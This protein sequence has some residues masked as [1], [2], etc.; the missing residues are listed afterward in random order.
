[1]SL[2]GVLLPG[3][4]VS[5]LLEALSRNVYFGSD[6]SGYCV[7]CILFDRLVKALFIQFTGS[8]LKRVGNGLQE[9]Q[10]LI[11]LFEN[12]SGQKCSSINKIWTCVFASDTLKSFFLVHQCHIISN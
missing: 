6:L 12:R 4:T 11:Q 1:M 7:S 9:C 8:S 5:L 3:D 2:G 10:Q